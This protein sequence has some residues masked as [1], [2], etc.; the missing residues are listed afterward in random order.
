[1]ADTSFEAFMKQREAAA[2]A[3]CSGDA[4][5]LGD[6]ATQRLPATFFGPRGG[7]TD[8]AEAVR[9]RYEGDVAA[10]RPGGE[11]HFE[12][13]H[14]AEGDGVAYWV[15]LQHATVR[16]GDNPEPTRMTL[17]ISEIFRRE[18]ASWKLVHRHA[19]SLVNEAK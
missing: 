9:G 3:Y 15:G 16:L 17:R 11:T 1:M 5:P 7:H 18:G 8:G 13:L 6:L 14:Q 19:D 2:R 4:K 12:V 10:F